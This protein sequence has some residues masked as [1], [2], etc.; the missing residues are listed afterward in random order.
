MILCISVLFSEF[1]CLQCFGSVFIELREIR[2][3]SFIINSSFLIYNP[4][5]PELNIKYFS[6]RRKEAKAQRKKTLK[7]F[8]V[9]L[10]KI[11]VILVL[12]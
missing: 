12:T 10:V 6:Q 2:N 3:D 8:I 1:Q 5:K 7:I 9:D 4:D 11:L